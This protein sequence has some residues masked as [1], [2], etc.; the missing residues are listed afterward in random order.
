ML[1]AL[2][3]VWMNEDI[4]NRFSFGILQLFLS[5]PLAE[6]MLISIPPFLYTPQKGKLT[7]ITVKQGQGSLIWNS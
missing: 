4:C 5:S 3:Q 7:Y 1:V 6:D 2:I